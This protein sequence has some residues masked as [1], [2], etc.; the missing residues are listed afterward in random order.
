MSTYQRGQ[1]LAEA[2]NAVQAD[3]ATL[4]PRSATP[5]CVLVVPPVVNWDGNCYGSAQWQLY[6]IAPGPANADAWNEL[7]RLLA[8]VAQALPI[9]RSVFVAYRLTPDAPQM[10]AYQMTFTEGVDLP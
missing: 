10:P 5:P 6:G 8:I 2:V 4:D 9:E 3:L 1:Q 7:D